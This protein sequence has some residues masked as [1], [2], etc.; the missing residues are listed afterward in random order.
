MAPDRELR[1]KNMS[2]RGLPLGLS[3]LSA[4]RW[5]VCATAVVRSV[6]PDRAG[7]EE[8]SVDII[9][10]AWEARQAE[11]RSYRVEWTEKRTDFKGAL[12]G[13][14]RMANPEGGDAPFPA[15]D[16]TFSSDCILARS[17]GTSEYWF[18]GQAWD[19]AARIL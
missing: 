14:A 1:M 16:T 4:M 12:T 19:L 10:R 3:R 15:E 13:A 5:V 18:K 17:G 6:L 8:L 2:C 7:A 11:I 9:A